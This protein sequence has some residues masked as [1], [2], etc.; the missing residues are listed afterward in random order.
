MARSLYTLEVTILDGTMTDEFVRRNPVVSRTIEIRSDQT[1]NQLHRAIF[2]ALDRWD[3]CHLSE[4][5]FGRGPRD[6]DAE[7][8]VLPFIYDDPEEYDELPAAGSMTRTRLGSLKLEPGGRFWYWYDFGDNWYHE[9]RVVAIGEPAPG[10]AYPRV[11]ARTGESPPQYVDWDEEHEEGQPEDWVAEVLDGGVAALSIESGIIPIDDSA[12]VA[13]IRRR[14]RGDTT[15]RARERAARRTYHVTTLRELGDGT[16]ELTT[17]LVPGP[18]LAVWLAQFT[19]PGG[20]RPVVL[21]V[22]MP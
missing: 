5:H 4:F 20:D 18:Y 11:I 2:D 17:Y 3:D 7:R 8:Y 10:V 21:S 6:R 19:E 14:I 12:F 9:I 22:E 15:A 16:G 1:L 13:W